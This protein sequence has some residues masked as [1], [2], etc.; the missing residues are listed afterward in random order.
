MT[1]VMHSVAESAIT[2]VSE[3]IILSNEMLSDFE[4]HYVN[5][6]FYS[7]SRGRNIVSK[8]LMAGSVKFEATVNGK[9]YGSIQVGDSAAGVLTLGVDGELVGQMIGSYLKVRVTLNITDDAGA[10]HAQITI[11]NYKGG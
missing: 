5:V 6:T 10:T 4:S 9:E 7:D 8:S 3:A 1:G 2:S 11:N